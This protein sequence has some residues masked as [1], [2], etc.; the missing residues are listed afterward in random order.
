MLA[1]PG[2]PRVLSV[3]PLKPRAMVLVYQPELTYS[4]RP[5]RG[6]IEA[7]GSTRRN[8]GMRRLYSTRPKRGPIEA[9]PAGMPVPRE[10]R[11][12]TSPQCGLIEA[13]FLKNVW[14]FFSVPPCL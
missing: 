13:S 3:A 7:K 10:T 1:P 6:P 2:I 4:T 9:A 8:A 11:Y 5:K 14:P 12:S